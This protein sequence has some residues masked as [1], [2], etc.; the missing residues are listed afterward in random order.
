[1]RNYDPNEVSLIVGGA[2]IAFDSMTLERDEDAF[3]YSAGTSG[4]STRTKNANVLAT[5]TITLPQSSRSNDSLSLLYQA[6]EAVPVLIKDNLGT[7]IAGMPLATASKLPA[8]NFEKE[9]TTREW[10]IK[11]DMPDTAFVGGN[12]E[13]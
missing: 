9:S 13:V 2:I 3:T 4:E 1:M 6:G 10:M 11:G 5:L 12:N 7:T 8:I